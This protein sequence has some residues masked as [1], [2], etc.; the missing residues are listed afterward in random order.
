M[1]CASRSSRPR[2]SADSAMAGLSSLMAAFPSSSGW[3]AAYTSPMPPFPPLAQTVVDE[4]GACVVGGN[5]PRACEKFAESQRLDASGPPRPFELTTKRSR[6]EL[7]ALPDG[8]NDQAAPGSSPY[9][10]EL[11]WC[12]DGFSVE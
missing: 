10:S 4:P 11:A 6:F 1:A 12:L 8:E 5:S 7:L 3:K 9:P 2:P